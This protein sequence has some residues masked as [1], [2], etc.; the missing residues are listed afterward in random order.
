ML[1]AIDPQRVY[2]DFQKVLELDKHAMALNMALNETLLQR[3]NAL[4]KSN[5][6]IVSLIAGPNTL[7]HALRNRYPQATLTEIDYTLLQVEK[8]P[9]PLNTHSAD[10]V[11][12][13]MVLHWCVV[14]ELLL[15]DIQRILK[16]GGMCLFSILGPDTLKELRHALLS[17][18]S[19]PY[20]PAFTD[21]HHWGDLFHRLKFTNS[22]VDVDYFS[23]YY[24]SFEVL[25][26]NL[27]TQSPI[28]FSKDVN[29]GLITPRQWCALEQA[30][31]AYRDESGW[32]VTLEV[33]YGIAFGPALRA[34]HEIQEAVIPVQKIRRK[35]TDYK[36]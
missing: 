15:Q 5:E 20:L 33:I 16:P 10:V 32:P 8:K 34:E 1:Q 18:S 27:R 31:A 11:F 29:K 12:C 13:P 28:Y 30:Y 4:N 2:R 6:T 25:M 14:P 36:N 17:F 35:N 3:L 24:P 23:V 9:L 21:M 26:R 7:S 19:K 22:V